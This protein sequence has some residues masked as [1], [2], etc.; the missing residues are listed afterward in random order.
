MRND[1]QSQLDTALH[2]YREADAERAR[3]DAELGE[4]RR[5]AQ[6]RSATARVALESEAALKQRVHEL[7]HQ[8]NAAK[9]QYVSQMF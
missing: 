3:L 5:L 4:S 9:E 1:F 2:Q 8:L 6:E 7:E